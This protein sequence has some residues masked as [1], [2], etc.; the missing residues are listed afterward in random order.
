[1]EDFDILKQRIKKLSDERS[2]KMGE[3]DS[4]T[5]RLQKEFGCSTL[6]EARALHKDMQEKVQAQKAT[7]DEMLAQVSTSVQSM[8]LAVR[9]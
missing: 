7:L 6:E 8:E 1:M 5:A 2:R 3:L 9:R 4:L